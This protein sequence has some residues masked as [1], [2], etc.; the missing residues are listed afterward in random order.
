MFFGF[1]QWA[2]ILGYFLKSNFELES[3]FKYKIVTEDLHKKD[4]KSIILTRHNATGF[5][6]EFLPTE[7]RQFRNKIFKAKSKMK[8]RKNYP[9]N[10]SKSWKNTPKEILY[11][12]CIIGCNPSI[13]LKE[14]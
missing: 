14:I 9:M 13:Q 2:N 8:S 4:I 6:L 1:V 5:N 7:I 12:L 10:F 3:A 11:R